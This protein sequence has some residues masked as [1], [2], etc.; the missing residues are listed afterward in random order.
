MLPA[1]LL[2]GVP[3]LPTAVTRRCVSLEVPH[4][5]LAD[6][7]E[8]LSRVFVLDVPDLDAAIG[9][10]EECSAAQFGVIEVRPAGTYHVDSAWTR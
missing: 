9:W 10:A 5:P 3:D 6:T 8:A 1:E 4:G 7:V 2:P